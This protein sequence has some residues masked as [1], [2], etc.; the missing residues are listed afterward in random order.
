MAK[1]VLQRM[2]TDSLKSTIYKFVDGKL[3]ETFI[4]LKKAAFNAGVSDASLSAYM[5]KRIKKPR[6]IPE[7]V[8]Y[9]MN[10]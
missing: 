7:N 9:K 6:K 3:T 10:H 2:N 4:G 1:V 5:R 8:E